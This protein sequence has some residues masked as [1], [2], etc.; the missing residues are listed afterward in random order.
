M[1]TRARTRPRA[2]ACLGCEAEPAAACSPAV[3]SPAVP[4]C[5]AAAM[6]ISSA[7]LRRRFA[8]ASLKFVAI[9]V[10]SLAALW[11]A[12][13]L[14]FASSGRNGR[15]T[16]SGLG[17]ERNKG[18]PMDTTAA[19]TTAAPPAKYTQRGRP[20]FLAIGRMARPDEVPRVVGGV[21]S[22]TSA[23]LSA[24]DSASP[25]LATRADG[26]GMATGEDPDAVRGLL[27]NSRLKP[28]SRF[29]ADAP[30]AVRAPTDRGGV[31]V[32]VAGSGRSSRGAASEVS[33]SEDSGT[34]GARNDLE[35]GLGLSSGG[36]AGGWAVP[37]DDIEGRVASLPAG[38]DGGLRGGGGAILGSGAL[39]SIRGRLLGKGGG[40]P[41]RAGG[42]GGVPK[43]SGPGA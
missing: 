23:E 7:A 11:Y 43:L 2:A 28:R 40:V 29:S 1:A 6:S 17:A 5:A 4:P 42:G 14:S 27:S 12:A 16:L 31:T 19:T 21:R 20:D 10:S 30:G 22:G 26:N 18:T 8:P 25:W 35:G 15:T 36:G 39:T 37:K 41:A 34:S 32:A 3:A 33:G 9:L 38:T 13:R 24:A